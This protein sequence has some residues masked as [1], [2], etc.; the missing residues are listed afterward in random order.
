MHK[1]IQAIHSHW[2]YYYCN[3]TF[4]TTVPVVNLIFTVE[5]GEIKTFLGLLREKIKI[6]T[7]TEQRSSSIANNSVHI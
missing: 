3:G 2:A 6:S 4:G 1:R 5:A 7:E